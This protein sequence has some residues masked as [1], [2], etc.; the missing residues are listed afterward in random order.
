MYTE[1]AMDR[2]EGEVTNSGI[3]PRVIGA[4]HFAVSRCDWGERKN[5]GQ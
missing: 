4:L 3:V 5:G 1:M 2:V